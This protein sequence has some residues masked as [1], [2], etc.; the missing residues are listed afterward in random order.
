MYNLEIEPGLQPAQK[1]R[2]QEVGVYR[3]PNLHSRTKMVRIQLDLGKLEQYPTNLLPGF[4]DALLKHV[5]GL[6]EHGCSYGE[7]GGLVL[8]MEEGTWLGHVAEHVAIELQNIAGADVARGKTRSVTNMPGVYNVMFEYE[9]EDLGLLAGRFAL[10]LVNFLLPADLQ[11]LAGAD[12]IAPSPLAQFTMAE[13]LRVLRAA[14]SE[15]AFGPTTASIVREAE[16]RSIPWRRLDNSSLVQLGYGKHL[17]RI[18]AS[19]SSLTSEIAA[20]IASDKELTKRLLIEAGLPAPWGTVVSSAEEAVEAAQSLG[21]PVVIK[22]VDGNHGRGVNIGLSSQ[23]EVE[24]GFEQARAHSSQ[25]LVEQQFVGGDHRILI[26]GG[27]LVAAAKRVP[28]HVIG[29]GRVT[30]EQLINR[31]NEDPRRGEGHEAALT[32]ISIDECLIHY[33][34]RS[35]FTLSSV[36]ERGNRSCSCQLRTCQPV[37]PP[38]T[39]PKTFI[40]TMH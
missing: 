33:I 2:V 11:G 16:A 7:P 26:I 1:L 25:V 17:K 34:A 37:A 6:R 23:S 19:C 24:W 29:N 4:V 35:G 13:A 38:S 14:H 15:I 28:A 20:E 10:E 36:P 3:G 39:A 21:L 12:M 8:R 9:N 5:P 31:E 40:R 22:P 30:I 18:R 32:R 27:R